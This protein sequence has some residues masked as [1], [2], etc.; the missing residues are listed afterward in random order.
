MNNTVTNIEVFSLHFT[1]LILVFKI[2]LPKHKHSLLSQEE[3]GK[4]NKENKFGL[5]LSVSGLQ[6][7]WLSAPSGRHL[8]L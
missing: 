7:K 8:V 5:G 6:Q 2:S 1:L 3:I 4:K